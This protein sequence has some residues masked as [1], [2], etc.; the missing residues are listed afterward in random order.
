MTDRF[1]NGDAANDK[2]VDRTNPRAWHGGDFRGIIN[3]LDY[4]KE[5]G[6]TAIWLTPW[7]DNPD[8]ANQCDKPWC[9]NTNYH[10]YHAIDYY[11]VE[12]HFGT[13]RDLRELI[14]AAHEN[15]IKVVQDQV[16]NHVGVQ[17][18]WSKNPP[19]ENWFSK[20]TQN[21]F[22]NSVLLSPNASQT[23]KDNL[24]KGRSMNFCPI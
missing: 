16:A 14:E 3:H 19:L 21:S 2:D 23:E 10:G 8:E 1:A 22:N 13:M 9:P 12:N 7:Y 15:G 17:H 18:P 24:L 11:A 4:L 5:L 20:F 6:V